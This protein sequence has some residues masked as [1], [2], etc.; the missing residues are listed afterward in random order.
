[1]HVPEGGVRFAKD[2]L[3]GDY[4]ILG[5]D[6]RVGQVV[7]VLKTMMPTIDDNDNLCV[8]MVKLSDGLV[9]T[10]WHPVWDE[11]AWQWAFPCQLPEAVFE[12]VPCTAVYSLGIWDLQSDDWAPSMMI[13]GWNV[14]TL[15]HG[16]QDDEVA[17]HSFFGTT[18]VIETLQT[19]SSWPYVRMRH[20]CVIRSPETGRVVGLN[21]S[22]EVTRLG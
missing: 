13:G 2:I 17:T 22:R 5:Q 9:V 8:Q 10:Y 7:C 1:V 16:I 20:D 3:V 11:A 21:M 12:T 6:G 19:S 15:A 4:V 14:A 18:R